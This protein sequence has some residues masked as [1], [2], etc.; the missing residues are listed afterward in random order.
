MTRFRKVPI[1]QPGGQRLPRGFRLAKRLA[2]CQYDSSPEAFAS[3]ES[4]GRFPDLPRVADRL[5]RSD[6][7][8]AASC[9]IWGGLTMGR[10][11]H[12]AT[13]ASAR[14]KKPLIPLE[15]RW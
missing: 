7:N 2:E 14:T 5:L 6:C 4:P 11:L 9:L 15:Y 3:R 1:P 8:H 12:S 13:N 10:P